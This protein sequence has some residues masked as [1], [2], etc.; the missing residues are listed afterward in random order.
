MVKIRRKDIKVEKDR[1][2]TPR[3]DFSCK[4]TIRGINQVV[5]VT[6]ISMGGFFFELQTQKKLKMDTLVDVSMRLPTEDQA[7]RFKARMINQN[8]RGIGCQFVGLSPENEEAV[9][10]C[11][12]TFKDTLPI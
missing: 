1:R 2:I 11:F 9:R 10:N 3:L 8:E 6:D 12:D 7:I 5:D 4:A